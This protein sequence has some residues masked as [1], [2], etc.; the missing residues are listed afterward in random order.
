MYITFFLRLYRVSL[1]NGIKMIQV[2]EEH[3]LIGNLES[4]MSLYGI[5]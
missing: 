5:N 3:F 1:I 4:E 2:V